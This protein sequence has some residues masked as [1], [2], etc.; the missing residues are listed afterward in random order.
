MLCKR[1]CAKK[2]QSPYQH[3]YT[4]ATYTM[5]VSNQAITGSNGI[6]GGLNAESQVQVACR[7]P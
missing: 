1:Y 6:L 5:L 3:V 7:F 4:A 2:F